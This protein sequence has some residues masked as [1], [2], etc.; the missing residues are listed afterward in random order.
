[1]ERTGG[2]TSLG[3]ALTGNLPGVV[4]MTSTGEPG[5]EDPQITI[6]GVT[7]WSNSDP[8]VLV[9]GIE[10]PMSSVDINSV[11][12]ISVLKDASATA[13][14]GVRGANG[15][16]LITTKRGAEGKATINVSA[17]STL[18]T[19]SKLPDMMDAYDALS[20]RNTVIER[21]L[22]YAPA[23]WVNYKPYDIL[24]KYRNPADITEAERYPNVDWV[25]YLLKD[26]TASYNAN[27][28]VSGG[29]RIVK[30]FASVDYSHEGDMYKK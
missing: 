12:S 15:V 19:Y 22:G 7:S 23:Q 18:K 10:R 6:R 13:V 11:A 20:L 21:E 30:Y 28:N 27:I 29:T 24:D 3:Q 17:S 1:M 14:F 26:V 16:I 9:D 25:D 4:T 2:V 5:A 8:L